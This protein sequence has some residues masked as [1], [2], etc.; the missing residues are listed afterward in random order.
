MFELDQ[1]WQRTASGLHHPS[2]L[3]GSLGS[4]GSPLRPFT[5]RPLRCWWEKL[6]PSLGCGKVDPG[7]SWTNR[8]PMPGSSRIAAPAGDNALSVPGGGAPFR[9]PRVWVRTA[10]RSGGPVPV[11]SV[12]AADPYRRGECWNFECETSD[13]STTTRTNTTA[14]LL[15]LPVALTLH[16]S[17]LQH[18]NNDK[19]E[20]EER[21]Y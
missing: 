1:N 8:I 5:S 17:L 9:G 15:A 3:P 7:R 13:E 4:L 18:C 16:C 11:G 14:Y 10:D 20:K 2:C 6:P 19:E 12:L 21:S